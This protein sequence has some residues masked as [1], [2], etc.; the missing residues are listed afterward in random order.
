MLHGWF[1]RNPALPGVTMHLQET[2]SVFT[3]QK[4]AKALCDSQLSETGL[5]KSQIVHNLTSKGDGQRQ[6]MGGFARIEEQRYAPRFEAVDGW[7]GGNT[8]VTRVQ[9]LR[10]CRGRTG[11]L[12]AGRRFWGTIN[13]WMQQFRGVR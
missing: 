5:V 9:P 13:H 4:P 12:S 1:R 7:G 2:N 8:C 3:E 10:H 6:L 11:E